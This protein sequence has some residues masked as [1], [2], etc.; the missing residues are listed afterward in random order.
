MKLNKLFTAVAL[1]SVA[2]LSIQ[3]SAAPIY[4]D[5][6]VT[7][8]D[9]QGDKNTSVSYG[10]Q[11][12]RHVLHNSLKKLSATGNGS[13][14]P[15]LLAQM[16]SYF[17]NKD[18]NRTI[19]DPVS[20]EGFA[21]AETNVDQLSK[22]KN[23]AGKAYKGLVPG[24]PG[25]MTA[26]EVL[27]FMIEKAAIADQGFDYSNGMDYPQLISKFTM[28]AVF[29]NQA[30]DSYLDEKLAADSKPNDKPYK[31][32]A[33]Y[34]GKEHVWDEAFGYFGTPAN[35]L[36]IDA[37]TVHA[38]GKGKPEAFTKADSN[39]N[40]KID[41]STEMTYAHASYAASAD[42]GGKTNYLHTI[43]Q[44]FVDGRLLITA[45]KGEKL[46]D[47]Q[48]SQLIAYADI[49][50]TN[51]ELVIAE[52]TFKYAGSV[53]SDVLKLQAGIE[54]N[55]DV[56][57][58]FKKYIHHWGELKGFSMSLQTS[59]KDLGGFAVSLNRLIGYSP[60]LVGNTQVTGIDA[61]GNYQQ[62]SSISLM[63]YALHMLKVQNLLAD[64]YALKARNKDQLANLSKLAAKLGAGKSTE[65]D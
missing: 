52:A 12:A 13:A 57:P 19:I 16:Q 6:P 34:T 25:N 4:A 28:G 48:R 24:W 2:T 11:M 45:A 40:G 61:E 33:A 30:V 5:F 49:I 62:S 65:N 36:N 22:G 37:A 39:G 46:T 20:K 1:A 42:K 58:L 63:Q 51:W 15:E 14:N 43:T 7:V 32:G 55:E 54:K 9:Y 8:K 21:I 10:G 41:L 53:Y 27:N 64:K 60:V 31:K 59:G 29:Y 35:T 56:K 3:A 50:K 26:A 18:E 47:Q 44:A 17:A 38:I 23:L